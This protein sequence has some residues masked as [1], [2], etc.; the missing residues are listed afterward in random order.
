[1]INMNELDYNVISDITITFLPC[2]IEMLIKGIETY[3]FIFHN[4]YSQHDDTDEAW[5]RD[6]TA[7]NLYNK[8][9][10]YK[11]ANNKTNYDVFKNCERHA[12]RTKRMVYGYNKKYY[13]KI[14]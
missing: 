1:M 5:M 8:L 9:M 13:K 12:N 10:K 6:F 11:N 2:E 4:I 3:M 7:M 14:A